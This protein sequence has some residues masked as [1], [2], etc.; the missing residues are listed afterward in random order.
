MFCLI[1]GHGPSSPT[2][3]VSA[4]DQKELSELLSG[5]VQQVRVVLRAV[6]LL[7]LTEGVSAPQV[8]RTI[9]L[10]AQA[11]RKISHRYRESGLNEP[12]MNGPSR[13]SR[14]PAGFSKATH[15]RNGVQPT[16]RGASAVDGAISGRTGGETQA[17]S[18]RRTRKPFGSCS[19][20]TT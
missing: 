7:Q 18:A 16:T 12:C 10:T 9:P 5:G 17:G 14:D 8:S 6:A 20:A 2:L 3:P 4:K 1:L 19:K 11:I 13:A 15:H